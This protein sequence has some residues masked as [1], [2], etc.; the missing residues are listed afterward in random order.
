MLEQIRNGNSLSG[1]GESRDGNLCKKE[2]ITQGN[3]CPKQSEPTPVLNSKK[4]KKQG[5]QDYNKGVTPA[6]EGMQKTHGSGFV[7]GWAGFYKE[8]EEHFKYTAANCVT[9]YRGE[10][11]PKGVR[12]EGGKARQADQAQCGKH[13][14]DHDALSIANSVNIPGGQEIHEELEKEVNGSQNCNL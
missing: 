12:E 14:G 11:P 9:N 8:T 6:I 4:Q 10:Q 13:M 3:E 5:G 7:G 1:L 2:G